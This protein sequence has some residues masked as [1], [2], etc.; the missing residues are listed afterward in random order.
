[1]I[2]QLPSNGCL[3][4]AFYAQSKSCIIAIADI[5]GNVE[6]SELEKP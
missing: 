1:L 2:K 6:I 4:L 5:A 3:A